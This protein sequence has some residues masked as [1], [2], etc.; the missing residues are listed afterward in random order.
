MAEDDTV[1]AAAAF[2]GIGW[3]FPPEFV[4][5]TG[6]LLMTPAEEDIEASLRVLFGTAVGER[7]L[8]PNY[9]LDMRQLLFEPTST[10]MLTF[11]RDRVKTAILIYEPRIDILSLDLDS[12]NPF[13]GQLRIALSYE[14]RATNSRFNLVFP[15]YLSDGNEMKGTVSPPPPG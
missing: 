8:N 14:V 15:F 10:T 2:L 12:P 7:F 1:D 4:I 3:S 5:E 13:E 9:G 6:E 11:L